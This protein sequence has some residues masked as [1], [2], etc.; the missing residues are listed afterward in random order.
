MEGD[1]LR[2]EGGKEGDFIRK[3]GRFGVV[4]GCSPDDSLGEEFKGAMCEVALQEYAEAALLTWSG[5]ESGCLVVNIETSIE[6]GPACFFV[7]PLCQPQ[8]IGF[9]TGN[10]DERDAWITAILHSRLRSPDRIDGLEA[11]QI[12]SAEEHMEQNA[13]MNGIMTEGSTNSGE[14]DGHSGATPVMNGDS[15]IAAVHKLFGISPQGHGVAPQ[16][17]IDAHSEVRRLREIVERQAD[18]IT[19]QARVIHGLHGELAT[20]RKSR[21]EVVENNLLLMEQ[22]T[23]EVAMIDQLAQ[24]LVTPMWQGST[25]E[26][27]NESMRL[28]DEIRA[29]AQSLVAE[30][31]PTVGAHTTSLP[32]SNGVFQKASTPNSPRPQTLPHKTILSTTTTP[33]M[34]NPM[35]IAPT[36]VHLPFSSSISCGTP[37]NGA[38]LG[39][40]PSKY[41]TNGGK[42]KYTPDFT[43][44]HH[45]VPSLARVTPMLSSVR[46]PFGGLTGGISSGVSTPGV[47]RPRRDEAPYLQAGP[48]IGSWNRPQRSVSPGGRFFAV[49]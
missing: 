8:W 14:P 42:V 13:N 1:F 39:V 4:R 28:V 27:K 20:E 6:G 16:P 33:V 44:N 23:V 49:R 32:M 48:R 9:I 24:L 5:G 40:T 34:P 29:V 41:L 37:S 17:I 15:G 47:I 3:E 45:R 26:D 43:P 7:K 11:K 18:T 36:S 30:A 46:P 25:D 12:Q 38:P 31:K 21:N 35:G 10:D 19:N 22:R 2:K